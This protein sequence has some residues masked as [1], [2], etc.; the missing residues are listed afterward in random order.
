MNSVIPGQIWWSVYCWLEHAVALG[1]LEAFWFHDDVVLRV[2]IGTDISYRVGFLPLG[3]SDQS[4][5]MN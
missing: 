1:D 3:L 4:A 2:E 5:E